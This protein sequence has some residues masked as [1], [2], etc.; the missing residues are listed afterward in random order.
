MTNEELVQRIQDGGEDKTALYGQL[1][2]KNQ[3]LIRILARRYARGEDVEDLMQEAYFPLVR[4]A[5][6]YQPDQQ[7]KFMSYASDIIGRHLFRYRA[8]QGDIL[9]R[10]EARER[11]LLAYNQLHERYMQQF[12]RPPMDGEIAVFLDISQEVAQRIRQEAGYS[13]VSLYAPA[14]GEDGATM[15]Q[16][17]LPDPADPIEAAQE[18]LQN[19][20][21]A[22]LLWAE[23]DKLE[24]RQRRIIREKYQ[25]GRTL[26]ETG[27]ELGITEQAASKH[28]QHALDNLRMSRAL[29]DYLEIRSPYKG[30]GLET[31]KRTFTSAPEYIALRNYGR[32]RFGN[33]K[34]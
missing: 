9:Q 8:Q 16:D 24:E 3:Q 28:A 21:L 11:L 30:T 17:V 33:Y 20:E 26:A 7:I 23:V 12:H 27:A 2:A 14:G 4:A 29:R 19:I 18:D 22:A 32:A 1:Y 25:K 34:P 15:L 13:V 6:S 5:D 31:F 10:S